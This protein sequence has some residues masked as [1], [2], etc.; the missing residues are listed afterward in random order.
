VIRHQ[1]DW[2]TIKIGINDLHRTLGEPGSLPPKRYEELYRQILQLTVEQTKAKVIL[3]DPFYIS[4]DSENGSHRSTVLGML[5]GYLRVVAKFAKEFG[6]GHVR[7]HAAFQRQLKFRDPDRFCP[8][9]VHP[10]L[11][12][13]AVIAFGLLQALNW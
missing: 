8:E 7:T 11:S 10:Y 4:T 13:H 3:I 9:P 2:V 6:T 5:P 1:P 12:G